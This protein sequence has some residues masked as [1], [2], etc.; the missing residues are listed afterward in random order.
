[1]WLVKSTCFTHFIFIFITEFSALINL[2]FELKKLSPYPPS[3]GRREH[4]GP[5]VARKGNAQVP[6]FTMRHGERGAQHEA[7]HGGS[8]R[9]T[10]RR[11][12]HRRLS[13]NTSLFEPVEEQKKRGHQPPPHDRGAAARQYG[14]VHEADV[15]ER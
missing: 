6:P 9:R 4:A 8:A 3:G 1:M 12:A 2:L 15:M 11:I 5:Y 10:M 14:P 7:E 13:H